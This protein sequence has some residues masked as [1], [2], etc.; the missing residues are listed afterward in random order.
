MSTGYF[1]KAVLYI[2]ALLFGLQIIHYLP[3]FLQMIGWFGVWVA[4]FYFACA[5][6]NSPVNQFFKEWL[7]YMRSHD[8]K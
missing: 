7:E 4:F 5:R 3:A 1:W 2:G 8:K 6:S